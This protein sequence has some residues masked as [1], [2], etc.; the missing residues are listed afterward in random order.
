MNDIVTIIA[1]VFRVIAFLCLIASAIELGRKGEIQTGKLSPRLMFR[2]VAF[3][4][5]I[6]SAGF[7]IFELFFSNIF[8]FFFLIGAVIFIGYGIADLFSDS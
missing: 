6:V 5:G 1:N 2:I 7:F 4:I 3:E 8:H